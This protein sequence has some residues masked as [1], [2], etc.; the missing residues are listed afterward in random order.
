MKEGHG[1][2]VIESEI[3]GGAKNI[4]AIA[5]VMDINNLDRA[6]RIKTSSSR[7]GTVKNVFFY[8]TKVGAYKDVAVRFN[9]FYEKPGNHNPTI[10]NIWVE[11]LTVE[12]GGK[13]AVLSAAYES[14]PL[15]DFT[16][17]NAKM[18]GVQIPYKVDYIKN[19][20]LKNVTDNEQPLTELKP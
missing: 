15:T 20:N 1:G 19:V 9:M 13:Y 2:V 11:N 18:I 7:G 4:Y 14:S 3:A 6:L 12:K 17:I 5:N 8:N 10:R 16:M